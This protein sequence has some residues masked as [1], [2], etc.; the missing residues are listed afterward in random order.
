MCFP[1]TRLSG[2]YIECTQSVLA[3]SAGTVARQ[4]STRCLYVSLTRSKEPQVRT[5]HRGWLLA[6]AGTS[7]QTQRPMVLTIQSSCNVAGLDLERPKVVQ[8]GGKFVMWVRGTG[9]GN[10]PQLLGVLTADAPTGPFTFVSNR[11]GSDDPFHTIAAGMLI[12]CCGLCECSDCVV[13]GWRSALCLLRD[14]VVRGWR[15]ALC[16]LRG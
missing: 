16:L 12:H 14:C 13:R 3:C 11:T 6:W 4:S 5:T 7:W 9:Y 2:L 15:S 8:C 10:S 1:H